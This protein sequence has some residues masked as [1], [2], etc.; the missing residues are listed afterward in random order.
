M[1]FFSG[2]F[3]LVRTVAQ[4][5]VSVA[6]DTASAFVRSV[7]S[8]FSEIQAEY[9]HIDV[10][11][12]KRERFRELEG[13]NDAIHELQTKKSRDGRLSSLEEERLGKL[14]AWRSSLREKVD[15]AREYEQVEDISKNSSEYESQ[16]VDRSSPNALTRLAGQAMLGKPCFR[17]G[18]PMALRWATEKLNPT[19]EDL[20]WGCTGFF[21]KNERN[22]PMCRNTERLSRHDREVF[23]VVR[24]GMELPQENL[25]RIVEAPASKRTIQKKLNNHILR[26]GEN[27]L[28][29]VHHL[30]MQLR[31]KR[32]AG[33]LLDTYYLRCS[34][35]EQTVKIK[36]AVQLD[37]IMSQMGEGGLFETV[38]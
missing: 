26:G 23:A 17:C 32:N 29:P 11:E 22:Q 18:S 33:C 13:T 28:C 1:G 15:R 34:K 5:A 10:A 16:I 2:L 21:V 35:C 14:L 20:F 8:K 36:S 4:V 25:N 24:P 7:E 37:E 30:P 31:E 6:V 3:E 19:C 12:K 38:H 9:G 27:Y